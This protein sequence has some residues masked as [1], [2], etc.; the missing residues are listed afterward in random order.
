MAGNIVL[1]PGFETG[2]FTDWTASDWTM[3]QAATAF[4]LTSPHGGTDFAANDCIGSSCTGNPGA[5]LDQALATT[6][7]GIYSLTFWWDSGTNQP[8]SE[9]SVSELDVFWGG[10]SVFDQVINVS[11]ISSDPG[12]IQYSVTGLTASSTSTVL[13]F[14]GRQDPAITS[15]L[16]PVSTWN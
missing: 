2:D 14:D 16:N 3:A 15:G 11:N 8:P 5:F 10:S 7:G 12:W 4:N 9:L 1:N 6:V 13:Q